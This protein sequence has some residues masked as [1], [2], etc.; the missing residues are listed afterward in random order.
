MLHFIHSHPTLIEDMKEAAQLLRKHRPDEDIQYTT[1]ADYLEKTADELRHTEAVA[2]W[3]DPLHSDNLFRLN[4]GDARSS[5]KRWQE[6]CYA[7]AKEYDGYLFTYGGILHLVDKLNA[8]SAKYKNGQEIKQP[9]W[10]FCWEYNV[11]PAISIGEGCT[12][13]FEA[14]RGYFT[15]ED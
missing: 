3:I 15:L 9:D 8:E 4:V 13:V 10:A 1:I 14:V 12:I 2:G 5:W 7:I 6:N 11:G